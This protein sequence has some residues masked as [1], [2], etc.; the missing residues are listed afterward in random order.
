[1]SLIGYLRVRH[2]FSA[3]MVPSIISQTS[4]LLP[5]AGVMAC[6]DTTYQNRIASVCVCVFVYVSWC[7]CVSF[8]FCLHY[9]YVAL[10]FKPSQFHV[11]LAVF[12]CIFFLMSFLIMCSLN[13]SDLAGWNHTAVSESE[14]EPER[15]TTSRHLEN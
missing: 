10:A 11:C 3:V 8:I 9:I 7:V 2:R 14:N 13:V 4:C 15:S 6:S 1:M 5:P 12:A